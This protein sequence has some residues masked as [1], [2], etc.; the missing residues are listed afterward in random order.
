MAKKKS[1][2]P[3]PINAALST[4]DSLPD[5]AQ[6]RVPTV[7]GLYGV[8]VVTAWRW[9]RNGTLPAPTK[10]GGVTTWRVGDL[11]AAMTPTAA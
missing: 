4:F 11:R 6:V 7:A 2:D 1:P 10:R 9:A 3:A 8:S 5:S